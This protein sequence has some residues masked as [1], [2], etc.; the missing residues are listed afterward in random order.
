M[1]TTKRALAI[2]VLSSAV[3]LG[4][5][6]AFWACLPAAAEGSRR[7]V[8]F[9]S[10]AGTL[11]AFIASVAMSFAKP[12]FGDEFTLVAKLGMA[13]AVF[14]AC[15]VTG[16]HSLALI[17]IGTLLLFA[18]TLKFTAASI[19]AMVG[20]D[21]RRAWAIVL[22]QAG[23]VYTVLF[24]ITGELSYETASWCASI[25]VL[26]VYLAALPALVNGCRYLAR[27]SE[28]YQKRLDVTF[29]E[30]EERLSVVPEAPAEPEPAISY[31]R[32]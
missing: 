12:D 9:I 2:Q 10:L 25:A 31:Q 4:L 8:V 19:Q 3:S 22:G 11:C 23:A 30:I 17:T 32:D 24:A 29:E 27:K 18:S 6:W 13:V 14:I 5:I 15:T 26:G 7:A 28:A 21:S 20:L 1:L 16:N